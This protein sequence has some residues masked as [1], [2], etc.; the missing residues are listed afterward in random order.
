MEVAPVRVIVLI[1]I[2]FTKGVHKDCAVAGDGEEEVIGPRL[3]LI[4]A[5]GQRGGGGGS[6]GHDQRVVEAAGLAVVADRQ[7]ALGWN[8]D[9][10]GGGVAAGLG[11]DAAGGAVAGGVAGGEEPRQEGGGMGRE[12]A[13]P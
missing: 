9:R 10:G 2:G 1:P 6:S 4:W 12:R 13:A 11:E 5:G 8:S 7:L 3:H